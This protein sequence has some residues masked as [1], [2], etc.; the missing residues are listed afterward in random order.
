MIIIRSGSREGGRLRSCRRWD[1]SCGL[2]WRPSLFSRDIFIVSPA[3]CPRR[4]FFLAEALPRGQ[5]SIERESSRLSN[6]ASLGW[7]SGFRGWD[8]YFSILKKGT[9]S[10]FRGLRASNIEQ[11]LRNSLLAMFLCDDAPITFFYSELHHCGQ[12][13]PFSFFRGETETLYFYPRCPWAD[14]VLDAK[15]EDQSYVSQHWNSAASIRVFLG[16]FIDW[17]VIAQSR[18]PFLWLPKNVS[19]PAEARRSCSDHS[20]RKY[21]YSSIK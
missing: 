14:C 13:I 3:Y 1:C 6:S 16:F 7:L 11:N 20:F 8:R 17:A 2:V 15:F 10:S 21:F 9:F 4:I 19:F 5:A 18:S 12:W